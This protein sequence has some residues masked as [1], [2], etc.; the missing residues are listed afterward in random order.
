MYDKL[1]KELSKQTFDTFTSGS[2]AVLLIKIDRF[3]IISHVGDSRA[4][5]IS[6]EEA[7]FLTKDHSPADKAERSRIYS[8]GGI[9]SDTGS[10][11]IYR[12]YIKDT[13]M[14]GLA[15]SRSLGDFCVKGVGVNSKPSYLVKRR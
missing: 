15:M 9:I 7:T 2:T 1:N 5:A 10:K 8:K 13:M 14:P 4:L 6:K 11:G 12:V 3:I